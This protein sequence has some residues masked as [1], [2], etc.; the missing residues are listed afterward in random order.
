MASI[1]FLFAIFVTG[2]SAERKLVNKETP[3]NKRKTRALG[4][5]IEK[6]TPWFI[7]ELL[8]SVDARTT[9]SEDKRKLMMEMM[10]ASE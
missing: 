5:M 1:G 10:K 3:S 9:K 8:I 6:V 2:R 4:D 7:T